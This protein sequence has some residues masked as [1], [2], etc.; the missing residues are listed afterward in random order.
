MKCSKCKQEFSINIPDN[1]TILRMKNIRMITWVCNRCN[2]EN[3]EY[4]R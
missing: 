3:R 2:I 1:H 4:V